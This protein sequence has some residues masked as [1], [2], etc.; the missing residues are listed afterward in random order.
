MAEVF[1]AELVGAEGVTRELVVKKMHP[2]LAL[3]PGAVAMFVDEARLAARLN[4]PNV[5][6]V[7]EF[8]KAG[9][10]YFLAMELVD[11]CDLA[12]LMKGRQ[13]PLDLGLVAWVA[14]ALLDALEYVHTLGNDRGAPMRLV[15]RDVSPHNVLLGRRG[16]VKL[17]DFGIAKAAERIGRETGQRGLGVKGKFAFMAPEQARGE[18]LDA[19]ADV[20]AAG[21]IVFELLS[22]RRPWR[23]RADGD[24]IDAVREGRLDALG[25]VWPGGDPGL[26]EVVDRALSP[27]RDLR[28]GSARAFREALAAAF[29]AMGV[30]PSRVALERAVGAAMLGPRDSLRP[31]QTLTVQPE[32]EPR[33]AEAP[34]PVEPLAAPRAGRASERPLPSA[35]RATVK[36]RRRVLFERVAIALGVFVVSVL[37]ERRTRP[38]PKAPVEANAQPR[39]EVRLGGPASAL[40]AWLTAPARAA[41]E[42]RCGCRIVTAEG[43]A[44]VLLIEASRLGEHLQR[45]ELRRLD[46]LLSEVD[47]PGFVS[48]R[49][50]LRDEA[51][52]LGAAAG[53][54]GEGT[55]LMPVAI[56]LVALALRG[57]ALGAVQG[58]LERARVEANQALA[59]CGPGRTLAPGYHP[60]PHNWTTHDATLAAFAFRQ[61]SPPR[62]WQIEADAATQGV[63]LSARIATFDLDGE[64]RLQRGAAWSRL[65]EFDALHASAGTL[66]LH[67]APLTDPSVAA[68]VMFVSQWINTPEAPDASA[69]VNLP[70]GDGF[71]LNLQHE[72]E[73]LGTRVATGRVLGLVVS[74]ASRR[75][76]VAARLVLALSDPQAMARAVTGWQMLAA[77]RDVDGT[78]AVT[79]P[80]R[81]ARFVAG[82]GV[83]N[84]ALSSGRF[85]AA[86]GSDD[87]ASL[88]A[89]WRAAVEGAALSGRCAPPL[90][91]GNR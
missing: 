46:S 6:Q 69:L 47:A 28:F 76:A 55:Y 24:L 85:A 75:P 66:A 78:E 12:T 14:E 5:V 60:D 74:R 82:L 67:P 83:I 30:R 41:V 54:A 44:D 9:D 59:S 72:T 7:Y 17:A 16:E 57:D 73:H 65:T 27:S 15:H 48:L 22:G 4:H 39:V 10:D 90:A 79:P 87:A 88:G 43:E 19:R 20:F 80:L 63:M 64:R 13:G 38:T 36:D 58:G 29:E 18:P 81:R 71:A 35:P 45:N 68:S 49:A 91:R 25:A 77:R 53:P 23:P 34:L 84:E 42:A 2:T 40:S 50:A 1:R 51:R 21:A 11:G 56:D 62:R 52:R 37:A 70:R 86:Q 31:E 89:A 33:E 26:S 61:M 8:G 3:D 32:P